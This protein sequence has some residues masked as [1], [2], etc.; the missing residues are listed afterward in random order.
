[1]FR[2]ITN[3]VNELGKT[4]TRIP[5]FVMPIITCNEDSFCKELL[6]PY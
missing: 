4:R 1:M 6:K 2:R 3:E 5:I